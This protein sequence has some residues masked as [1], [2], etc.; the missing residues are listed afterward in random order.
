MPCPFAPLAPLLYD[1]CMEFMDRLL[2]DPLGRI[3]TLISLFYAFKGARLV[4][5]AW[6]RR[7]TFNQGPLTPAKKAWAE[8]AAFY[9]AI[10][11]GV[12]IHELGHALAVWLFGGAVAEFGF[13]F[14]W[15]YVMPVGTF[16]P[17][18][19]WFISLAGTLGTLLY[20]TVVWLWLR[21]SKVDLWRYFGLRTLRFHLYYALIYYPL[22]TLFTF[23]GDWRT[24]YN[25][26]ATPILSGATLL[27][28]ALSL[29]L[30]WWTDRQ[31]WY[32]RPAFQ[33]A[34]EQEAVSRLRAQA[35][36]DPE[37]EQLQLQTIR[38]LFRANAD[39]EG[40]ERLN[41]FLEMHPHSAEGHLL[42][43]FVRATGKRHLPA[44][45]RRDAQEALELGLDPLN[46]AQ[47]HLLLAQYYLG[48][49]Q[50]KEAL[51]HLDRALADATRTRA[52]GQG[53]R[54]QQVLAQI[55]YWRAVTYRRQRQYQAAS[56]EIEEA[57][58]QVKTVGQEQIPRQF[59]NERENI[60]R[61]AGYAR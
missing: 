31:G 7:D 55:H 54:Q 40:R 6:Q 59:E 43:A 11:P 8:Q 61:Q 13:G 25:F 58:R 57:I 39:R 16:S 33:S 38:A 1:A 5:E 15:G 46:A 47:A 3:F 30:F 32:E 26:S 12:F 19:D 23:I 22:F 24:I 41:S 18:Q 50:M 4:W 35:D 56:D 2:N 9:V 60:R 14:Y 52:E 51:D 53:S 27:V 49:E 37:D 21:R 10:P 45:A 28:H 42:R 29:G 17:A 44:G 36:L 34:G 48:V 20:A